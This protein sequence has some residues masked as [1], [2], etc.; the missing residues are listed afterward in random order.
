MSENIFDMSQEKE[1]D[2]WNQQEQDPEI[3]LGLPL[4]Q[5][6]HRLPD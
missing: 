1:I 4:E 5:H 2:Y 6:W 3:R